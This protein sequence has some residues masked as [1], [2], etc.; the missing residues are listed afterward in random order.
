[1]AYPEALCQLPISWLW[2]LLF[3]TMFFL[4]GLA[5]QFGSLGNNESVSLGMTEVV[6]TGLTDQFVFLQP[7]KALVV[8]AVVSVTF[9]IGLL[10]CTGVGPW[11]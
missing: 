8:A 2:T 3:F 11:Q 1:M 4:I 6:V 7:Y 10:L 5:A 9:A